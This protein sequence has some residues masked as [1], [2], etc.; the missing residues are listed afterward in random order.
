MVKRLEGKIIVFRLLK[1]VGHVK[2]NQFCRRFYGY[3]DRSNLGKYTYR[4]PGF[5]DEIP[6]VRVIRGVVI[7]RKED[8]EKVVDFLRGF[9]AEVYAWTVM[10]R[11]EDEKALLKF[12]PKGAR[13]TGGS[14][15]SP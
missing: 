6:H 3:L 15:V 8:A 9:D 7:V 14:P 10:L 2:V 4:R 1:R 5:L 13:P 12:K 11:P